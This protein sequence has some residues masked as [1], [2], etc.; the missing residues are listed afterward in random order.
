[1]DDKEQIPYPQ[2]M[3]SDVNYQQFD[4]DYF[5]SL[6]DLEYGVL[7][8]LRDFLEG[9]EHALLEVTMIQVPELIVTHLCFYLGVMTTIFKG[10]EAKN[11]EP[12]II[13]L[14]KQHAD[15]AY[16]KFNKYPVNLSAG[17]QH[18]KR[19]NLSKLRE[20]SPGSIVVQTVRL[21]RIIMD[22]VDHLQDNRDTKVGLL[23]QKQEEL[24]CPQDE[25]FIFIIPLVNEQHKK[26]QELLNGKSINHA[27]NQL[28]LQIGWLIGYFS[29]LDKK[30]PEEGLY[31]EYGVPS[32]TLYIDHTHRM[33]QAIRNRGQYR[34]QA[35]SPR[36]SQPTEDEEFQ[37]T[38]PELESLFNEIRVLSQKNHADMPLAITQFQKE[39]AIVHAGLEKLL[40]ELVMEKMEVK[41]I[42]M[43]LFYFWFII[44][45]P[46]RGIKPE[47]LENYSPYEEMVNII[48]L[49]KKTAWLLPEPELTSELKA[50]NAKMQLLKSY[51]PHP[52]SYDEVP[53]DKVAHQSTRVDKAIHTLTSDYLKQGYHLEV[54]ANVLFSHW[55]RLSV[56]FGVSEN[57]W[58]KMDY[59]FV[60][61]L[62]AVRNYLPTIFK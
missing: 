40:I 54:I 57:V 60:E 36:D 21:G 27:I 32:I 35:S 53:Q 29:H 4:D 3:L 45:A 37:P 62:T 43:S 47:L 2:P 12:A 48:G 55:L 52:S 25:F 49:V 18:E 15:L 38:D 50:L 19:A 20:D 7:E 16:L 56:L 24:F 17:F 13:R 26:W 6:V 51:L 1:M 44:D 33:I 34:N 11:L 23:R 42:V 28:T 41:I 58:Q 14:L 31:L 59:Y 61:I 46:L 8:N 5:E 10:D 9:L 39:T 22:M 30:P